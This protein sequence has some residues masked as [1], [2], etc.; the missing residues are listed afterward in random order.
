MSESPEFLGFPQ[1]GI[2]FLADLRENNDRDWF[3]AHK[4]IY[5]KQVLAPAQDLAF[6][7]GERLKQEIS[8]GI[9]YDTAANGS[10]SVLR[11]YRDL[12]FSVD[13]R[14]YN[15]HVRLVFWEGA[16]KKMENPSFFVRIN[17]DGVGV[18][19]G[20]HVFPKPV[21]A[22]YRDAVVDEQLGPEL[23]ASLSAVKD[24]G[25]YTVGG[26][27]YKRVPRGY[28]AEHPRADLLRYN[29]LWAH[30]TDPADPGVIV[31]PDLVEVCLEHCRNMAP[32]HHW[33]VKVGRRLEQ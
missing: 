15:T 29:G 26:E 17:P 20:V 33:L 10:G 27:H 31:T 7:L 19:S 23:E 32:L 22:A 16:R 18:Y 5:R 28:D 8:P 24:A 1:E 6:A 3:E 21:L 9:A 12:R 30:T 13:K 25:Q 2:R 4:D 14:P 11:I